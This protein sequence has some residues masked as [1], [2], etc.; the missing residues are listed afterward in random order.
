MKN[1][2]IAPESKR[3]RVP[4]GGDRSIQRSSCLGDVM[5]TLVAAATGLL[6]LGGCGAVQSTAEKVQSPSSKKKV[7]DCDSKANSEENVASKRESALMASAQ[8]GFGE[9]NFDLC[10]H[11]HD[12]P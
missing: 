5:K 4:F 12:K 6:A 2:G 7:S 8:M 1:Q 10:I 3:S 11:D 9:R